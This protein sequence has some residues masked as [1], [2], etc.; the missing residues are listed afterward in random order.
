MRRAE[1]EALLNEQ[2]IP[3]KAF[4]EFMWGQTVGMNEDG[5]ADYYNH[6][7]QRF[8]RLWERRRTVRERHE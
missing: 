3:H 4:D 8:V 2:E 1:V 7:V 6:D 5:T